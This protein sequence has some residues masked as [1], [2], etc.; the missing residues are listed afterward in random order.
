MRALLRFPF[1]FAFKAKRGIFLLHAFKV[2]I[3]AFFILA[4]PTLFAQWPGNAPIN[5]PVDSFRIDGTLKANT[6]VGDWVPGTGSGGYVIYN[7]G[8]GWQPLNPATTTFIRDSFNSTSDR[9]FSGSA[10]SDNPNTQWKWTLGKATNKCDINT[11]MY[12]VSSSSNSKWIILGGDR[13]TTTGTSYIDFE[14][15]QGTLTRNT[16]NDGFTYVPPTDSALFGGRVRRDF[17]LSMEYSNGGTNA[18]V[19]YY[20]WELSSGSYKYVE[21]A[22]PTIVAPFQPA[23]S[24]SAFGKT[25]G[26]STD[27]PFGAFGAQKYIPYAFVEAAVNIDA[28]LG[29]SCSGS[30]LNIKTIFVKTKASDSYNAALKDFVEPQPV[31]F[32][33]GTETMHYSSDNFCKSDGT[34]TPTFSGSGTFTAAA[35]GTLTP[36]GLLFTDHNP[37][38]NTGVIDLTNSAAGSYIITYTF[39]SGGG[40]TGS[41]K[42]TITI[43]ANPAAPSANGAEACE[44]NPI[45]TLTAT[46][47]APAGGSIVWYDAATAGSI[48][49]NPTLSSV[50]TVTYYAEAIASN[51]CHSV[52][53]T[54]ATLTIKGAPAAPSASG[55]IVCEQS[56]IQTLTATATA[57]A[58][59]SIVWY[60]AATGGSIVA[61]PTLNS[62]GTVTYYAEAV[63]S[64]GCHSLSRTAATLTIKAAPAAP[65]ASGDIACEQSPIQTLTATATAPAGGSIV[66]YTAATGGSVV[67]NPTLSSVGTLTYYAEA[68][69]SNGCHS[70]SRTAATLTI[71]GAPAAPSASGDLACEQ[72]PIQTLTATATPPS[73]GS[74]VW[75]SAATGGSIVANPTLNSV[76]TVTYYAEAIGSNG[77]HSLSRTAAT[78]TIKGAPAAPSANGA[79]E[80]AQNPIQ[81]LTA[82]AT[83][84]SGG[85]IVW[86]NLATGGSIVANPTLHALGTVTYYAEAIG[87]NGCHSLTRSAATLTIKSVPDAPVVSITEPS[88]CGSATAILTVTNPTAGTYTLTQNAGGINPPSKTYPSPDAT[89]SFSGLVPG[90]GYNISVSLNGCASSTS[91]CPPVG[92]TTRVGSSVSEVSSLQPTVKAY[93]NPFS[94][95]IRFII[96]SPVGGKGNLEVY[97]MMGQKVR[98]VY[99]GFIPSGTQTFELS[100][101]TQRVADL[102][103][104]LRIGD[105]KLSGKIL[106][107]NQ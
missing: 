20:L 77:C 40:C 73:G 97:N 24:V 102:I 48:V 36:P 107:I 74:I 91:S 5:P 26:D 10:F 75:Y 82:T 87:S 32:H 18:T 67:A 98:T 23:G 105:K 101:P 92:E 34:A 70:L 35:Y 96:T 9:I 43:N 86:Y 3:T 33:F 52:S 50:G 72:N 4:S 2:C 41:Q 31:S 63:G 29:G 17:V 44:Q 30:G 84:P 99:S 94:D 83:A 39:S 15:L 6:A 13:Y 1:P 60:N 65:S 79:I 56:P 80:C 25:N 69:G 16:G 71:K 55:D 85:S 95:R 104:V 53:R 42:D 12:H 21:H 38:S 7:P 81:T 58:G 78:L 59:G 45:Q 28:I 14:F 57:P 90:K 103:Y 93:P 54:A 47:T 22:I 106:Q 19:H 27:V 46:A 89:I 88:L 76:G 8:A 62:V 37:V 66:W 49:A 68:V 64:N 61:N 100:L 11:A 51:G